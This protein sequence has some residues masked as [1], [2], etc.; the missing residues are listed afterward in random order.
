MKE[1]I[2]FS[3]FFVVIKITF[4]YSQNI[5]TYAG[6]GTY[7]FNGDNIL[8]T[9][10]SIANA[11]GIA[12][13]SAG[14]L[15]IADD[16]NH[17][18]RKVN[19]SGIITTIAGTGIGGYSGDGGPAIL[20]QLNEPRA[21]AVDKHG[22]VYISDLAN[23]R[24]RK[25]NTSGIIT[26]LAGNGS[27]GFSGDGGSAILASFN[28]P[29]G[30]TV[31]LIGNVYV[32]DWNNNRIRKINTSGVINT[33]AGNGSA[34]YSGDGGMAIN[35]SLHYPHDV[36]VDASGNIYIADANNNRIRK[37]NAS[38]VISTFAGGGSFFVNGALATTVGMDYPITI[39]SDAAGNVYFVIENF[40]RICKVDLS[41]IISVVAGPWFPN[42]YA[43]DGGPAIS[44]V[45]YYPRGISI[46]GFGN[47]F[48]SDTQNSRV[49][50][51]CAPPSIPSQINGDNIICSGTSTHIYSVTPTLG[52]ATYS[53]VLPG[54]WS[55]SSVTNTINVTSNG[56]NGTISVTA[57]NSCGSASGQSTIS[58][59]L[60]SPPNVLIVATNSTIC[61]KDTV[62]LMGVNATSYVWN[63]GATS[64]SISPSPSITTTYTVTGT[65]AFGC[66]NSA[67]QTISVNPLPILNI[68]SSTNSLC[69]GQ[70]TTLTSTG[71]TTYTWY[72]GS[73]NFSLISV[74][75]TTS[76]TYTLIGMNSTGC[77]NSIQYTIQVIPTPTLSLINP[78]YYLCSGN[79]TISAN[80]ASSYQWMPGAFT[81]STIVVSPSVTT[82]YTVV[83]ANGICTSSAI[84]TVSLGTAPPLI[85]TSNNQSG[86]IGT[87]FSL[88]N[89]S[90]SFYPFTYNWGDNAFSTPLLS[91]HCYS[92]AG[93]FT[94][95][96][97]ATFSTGCSVISAN[98]LT[99]SVFP[100]PSLM[101]NII[102]GNTQ[103]INTNIGIINL[104]TGGNQYIWSFGDGSQN[105]VTSSLTEI[106]HS[107]SI[108]GNYCVKLIAEN[109]TT[110]C[111]D[112]ISQCIDVL[113]Q[114]YINSPNVFTPNGDG[115][116]DIFKFDS[117]CIDFLNVV[118]YNRWGLKIL[119]WDKINSGW[120]GRTT[121][122]QLVVEGTYFYVL[123]YI[124]SN[125][126]T[127]TQSRSFSLFR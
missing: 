1:K 22:N 7:G 84:S 12:T 24:I 93:E 104:S 45:F 120:D 112:S 25:I 100:P 78:L 44:A 126:K 27:V 77:I 60:Q 53:W 67:V 91:Q 5:I 96:A 40:N 48:I 23:C 19:K 41:G 55:G 101:I 116:N 34:S 18:I 58:I 64:Q 111:I 36:C 105:V 2:C 89:S 75:P 109:T 38:G 10:A 95:S 31:D 113:C 97:Q 79:A 33:F 3:F 124:D 46:D 110:G 119:E 21:V 73:S 8:A 81:G 92:V 61:S 86:C 90:N 118:I 88:S 52:A 42:G 71:A 115:S 106:V 37:V 28:R 16:D 20:A 99:I 51:I 102:G 82:N 54:G 103:N 74:T 87:C 123:K 72:P 65:D 56:T 13:D 57:I 122:G 47:L 4:F 14:N 39:T 9:S 68:S 83:G 50:V 66:V 125:G 85:L 15:Y 76:T 117:E 11:T 26:T 80:G 114:S 43:G 35:A 49:R 29:V 32:A 94:V 6:N 108:T 63:T 69:S 62:I 30:I 121:S 98:T 59:G 17:R 107:Y 127:V 70:S